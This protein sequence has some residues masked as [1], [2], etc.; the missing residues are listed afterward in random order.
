MDV[1]RITTNDKVLIPMSLIFFFVFFV[2][3]CVINGS[4]LNVWSLLLSIFLIVSV[5][6]YFLLNSPTRTPRN[7]RVSSLFWVY[8]V[9]TNPLRRFPQ[10]SET[11]LLRTIWEQDTHFWLTEDTNS[12]TNRGDKV[13]VKIPP[14]I[15]LTVV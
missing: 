1:V 5:I 10:V 2:C 13:W 7:S 11:H 3:Y 12:W 4:F 14:V 15:R 8:L 6:S 9:Q